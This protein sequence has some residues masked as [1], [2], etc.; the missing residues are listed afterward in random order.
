[1]RSS[2]FV[3]SV[4]VFS[5]E[6][7][8]WITV[9]VEYSYSHLQSSAHCI[10]VSELKFHIIA[11]VCYW[12]L[13]LPCIVR[14]Q[15]KREMLSERTLRRGF[16]CLEVNWWSSLILEI[17]NSSCGD[18]SFGIQTVNG[19]VHFDLALWE[20]ALSCQH[21]RVIVNCVSRPIRVLFNEDFICVNQGLEFR[22]ACHR[23]EGSPQFRPNCG[24]YVPKLAGLVLHQFLHSGQKVLSLSEVC[25]EV[26]R[27]PSEDSLH[28]E[29]RS[30]SINGGACV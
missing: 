7:R 19:L 29:E 4:G 1:M 17:R 3:N 10:G 25:S 11:Q 22:A 21:V 15:H 28:V 2:G 23:S 20:S 12:D 24:F 16:D 30:A 5:S 6:R 18:Y 27:E 9:V 13:T 26:V 8:P 14:I